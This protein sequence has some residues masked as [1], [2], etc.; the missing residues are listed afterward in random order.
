MIFVLYINK[1]NAEFTNVIC[2]SLGE[3]APAKCTWWGPIAALKTD[4]SLT[5]GGSYYQ[6]TLENEFTN[7]SKNLFYVFDDFKTYFGF[8][9]Y[10]LYSFM[11]ILAFFFILKS[12]K[13]NLLIFL[14]IFAFIFS[15]PLFHFAQDWPRW[16]SIHLHLIVFLIFFLQRLKFININKKIPFHKINIF[17]MRKFKYIF[18]LIVFFYSTTFHHHHFLHKGVRLELTYIKVLNKIIK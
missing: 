7:Q 1:G 2:A 10:I 9:F 5:T 13:K 14:T 18:L 16:F 8:I 3:F 17:F 11:P 4:V 6:G 12:D 15:L